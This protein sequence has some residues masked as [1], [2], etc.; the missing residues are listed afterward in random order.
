M[1]GKKH[2]DKLMTETDGMRGVCQHCTHLCVSLCVCDEGQWQMS[3]E[4]AYV[5]VAV[6]DRS[7]CLALRVTSGTKRPLG[8]TGIGN[9][10]L[11][12]FSHTHKM[13]TLHCPQACRMTGWVLDTKWGTQTLNK[14]GVGG[15]ESQASDEHEYWQNVQGDI[16][17][18]EHVPLC[19][20]S[21][22]LINLLYI[23]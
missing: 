13:P 7:L 10:M 4:E 6:S 3:R 14:R 15:V 21:G 8:S 18:E 2:G 22:S 9:Y 12:C 16:F 5:R 19:Y 1:T 17:I 23:L 20:W 11:I